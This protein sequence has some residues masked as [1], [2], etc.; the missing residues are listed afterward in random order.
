MFD[1]ISTYL[2]FGNRFCG[3]EH[4]SEN[5]QDKLHV[6]LLK[7]A[8][9][10]VD[11]E[12]SFNTT[13]VELLT[14]Q[15][16]KNQHAVLIINNESVLTKKIK[17]DQTDDLKLVH[18]AFPNIKLEDFYY[19]VLIQKSIHFVSICRK[20]YVDKL[21]TQY[22]THGIS[23]INI[24]LGSIS[25]FSICGFINSKTILTS[26]TLISIQDNDIVDIEKVSNL[27][28]KEYDVNGIKV[29]NRQLI[30]FSGALTSILNNHQ[31]H[32]NFEAYKK[33]LINNYKQSRFFSQ[34]LK[35]G[36]VF[37]L[38][39]LLINFFFFNHY[40]NSVNTL[41]QTSQI[42][43]TTKNKVLELN[44]KVTKTQKM[45]DDMLKSR[46]SKSSYYVNAI[47]Q[48]LPTTILLSELN[49]QPL[50]KRIKAEQHIQNNINTILI[51][52]ASTSSASFS[53]WI[54]GL[55]S[56]NWIHKV[57]IL[58]Y[59]DISKSKSNFNIKLDIT[60]D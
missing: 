9:K 22:K 45:V 1:V 55:D 34:F 21:I 12:N 14:E 60:D 37:L 13:T 25:A 27:E 26:N 39:L 46:T 23:I 6:T 30:S 42:N 47:V 52:G 5:G 29:S 17:S 24:S 50:K 4:A 54:G 11:V 20:D 43:Q 33:L 51:S 58:S 48:S 41:Q 59:E 15:L 2:Q 16:P 49:Y 40:F 56:A 36:L 10:E 53:K 32:T 3:I 7:K 44:E 35:F 31:S 18:K 8:K 19:E 38:G 28:Q 57:E